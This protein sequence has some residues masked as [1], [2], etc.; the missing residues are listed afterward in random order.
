MS[1]SGNKFEYINEDA[2]SDELKC[3]ICSEPFQVP[4]SVDCKHIF[5]LS[6]ITTWAQLNV[7]CP[8][9]RYS[10]ATPGNYPTVTSETLLNQLNGLLVRCLKCDKT[11]IKRVDFDAHLERCSKKKTSR[12][13][14]LFG[15]PWHSIKATMR[16]K[17]HR[18]VPMVTVTEIVNTNRELQRSLD[19]T[20]QVQAMEQQSSSWHAS[21]RQGSYILTDVIGKIFMAIIVP[22]L[23]VI[24][25]F[26]TLLIPLVCVLICAA[27]ALLLYWGIFWRALLFI[28]V[29]LCCM[30]LLR[31]R[32][33]LDTA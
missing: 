28:F 16:T 19:R 31:K 13:S 30:M 14:N 33:W 15:K 17:T 21:G 18:Q 24:I 4:V 11:E 23:T 3:I 5:C 29:I 12:V 22:L 10:F 9:C 2:I 26:M 6:C 32:S 1:R 7:S 27:I 25:N 8:V 20:N